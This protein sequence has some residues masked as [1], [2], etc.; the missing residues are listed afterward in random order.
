MK[1]LIAEKYNQGDAIQSALPYDF[2]KQEREDEPYWESDDI[3]IIPLQGQ[4][5][6]LDNVEARDDY[7]QFPEVEWQISPKFSSKK[8]L[9]ED[10]L[11]NSDEIVVA[12]DL[13]REGQLI[14]MLSVFLPLVGLTEW[15]SLEE[16]NADV[17]RMRYSSM[18]HDEIRDAW[19]V[20]SPPDRGLYE[21]GLARAEVDYRVG[22]N[23]SYAINQCLLRAMG[24]WTGTSAGRVQTPLLD[25]I[26]TRVEEREAF[27]P[28]DYWVPRIS[29]NS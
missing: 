24:E 26:H 25:I 10:F 28:D 9:L 17:T 8:H 14:G 5:W 20:R 2:D 3:K 4:I 13:D 23:L 22:L 16:I 18:V 21:K 19:E 1:T 11:S 27:D 7:P 12:T 6:E 15:E 29:I